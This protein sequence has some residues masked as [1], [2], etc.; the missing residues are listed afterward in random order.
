MKQDDT[1]KKILEKALELF[2]EQGYDAVSVVDIAEAVGIKAPSLYNHYESKRAIFDAIVTETANRYRT[3]TDKIN[4]H[5][6]SAERDVP[7]FTEITEKKLAEKVKQIFL[8]SLHDETIR[9]FR[10][11]MTIEQFRSSELSRLY[12]ER[13]VTR[14]TEYH[15]GIFRSL[16]ASGEIRDENPETLALMYISPVLTLL[17]IC[18]REPSREEECTRR[19]EEHIKLFFRTFNIKK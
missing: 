3:C 6:E 9:R 12:T 1:K 13:Y 18:D 15:A 14:M 16:I 10:R 11:M 5:V 4:I 2:S 8:Y 7:F 17:G 19:L